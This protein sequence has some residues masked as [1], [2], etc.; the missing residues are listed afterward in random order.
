MN[1]KIENKNFII[2]SIFDI[3]L[4]NNKEYNAAFNDDLACVVVFNK[5]GL[6]KKKDGAQIRFSDDL[7][8]EKK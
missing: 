1:I 3:H 6:F 4:F 5:Y 8:K 7:N 2:D